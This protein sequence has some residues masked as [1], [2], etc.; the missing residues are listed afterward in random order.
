MVPEYLTKIPKSVP[1]GHIVVHNALQPTRRLRLGSVR[2]FRAWL[3]TP[4]AQFAKVEPCRCGWAPELGQHYRV[5]L[6]DLTPPARRRS[7]LR[8]T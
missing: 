6:P 8:E 2:G 5:V 4:E 7:T 3:D 1:P